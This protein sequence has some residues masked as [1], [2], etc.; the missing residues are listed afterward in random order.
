[1]SLCRRPAPHK[2]TA[3]SSSDVRSSC[4]GL[5][6]QYNLQEPLVGPWLRLYLVHIFLNNKVLTS[7]LL[8][9][10]IFLFW[11]SIIW[12]H[13]ADSCQSQNMCQWAPRSSTDDQWKRRL[14][15]PPGWTSY[16][17]N[18]RFCVALHISQ[19][20]I[21]TRY[22]FMSR[23]SPVSIP[24][25]SFSFWKHVSN[26][27]HAVFIVSENGKCGPCDFTEPGMWQWNCS[28]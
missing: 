6:V 9:A 12:Y 15:Y 4:F 7:S 25:D 28:I 11:L 18:R 3:M 26:T 2:R 5:G 16:A 1:M 8:V 19:R 24:G 13:P 10:W 21:P 20:S 17:L 23:L 27:L 14:W 22:R